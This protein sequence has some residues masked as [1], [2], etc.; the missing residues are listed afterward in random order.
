MTYD[1]ASGEVTQY[2]NG[3]SVSVLPIE[4]DT[5]LF[6]GACELGN[7]N[8]TTRKHHYPV[9]FLTG[10]VDEFTFY[11]RA[12]TAIEIANLASEN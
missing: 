1:R 6:F 9:R 4:L 5:N 7:W 10:R 12:L 2:V 11:S 8:P 3:N